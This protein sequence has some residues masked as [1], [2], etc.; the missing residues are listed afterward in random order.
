MADF[1]VN[2]TQLS[3]PSGAGTAP[4]GPAKGGLFDN[5]VGDLIGRTLSIF[6]KGLELDKKDKAKQT[7]DAVLN[8]YS[9]RLAGISS[10]LEQGS[11]KP[12]EAN[13]RQRAITNEFLAAHGSLAPKFSQVLDSFNGTTL[14]TAR[15]EE[16][17][18]RASFNKQLDAARNDGI[19]IPDSANP[20]IKNQLV[21]LHQE[22]KF[23]ER[24][25]QQMY[26]RAS[27]EREQ[28]RYT[29]EVAKEQARQM[30]IQQANALADNALATSD[31]QLRVL[32]EAVSNGSMKPEDAALQWNGYMSRID[33]ALQGTNPEIA[34]GYRS[35]F[36][37]MREQG[38]EFFKPGA[39]TKELE[40]A[41]AQRQLGSKLAV[42][43]D[44]DV[45]K[46]YTTLEL[47]KNI[48]PVVLA[49]TP[50]VRN[51]TAKL[52]NGN[53]TSSVPII[54]NKGDGGGG[55]TVSTQVFSVLKKVTDDYASGKSLNPQSKQEMATGINKALS[56]VGASVGSTGFKS[57]DLND[58]V[59]F[60]SSPSFGKFAKENM[61]DPQATSNARVAFRQVYE[62]DLLQ[63]VSSILNKTFDFTHLVPQTDP[64]KPV[65]MTR[66]ETF[67]IDA[68]NIAITYD[69][70]NVV[71]G[72]KKLPDNPQERRLLN[73]AINE[74]APLQTRMGQMVRIRAHLAGSTDYPA[75][76]EQTKNIM[77]GQFFPNAEA[78]KD[79][80]A[81]TPI[82]ES[83]ARE[84]DMKVYLPMSPAEARRD[85]NNERSPANL[86]EL[87]KEI[88]R[89]KNP[90]IKRVL[91]DYRKQLTGGR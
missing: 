44:P 47:F 28:G 8:N 27:Y 18:A 72:V 24:Q 50:T 63:S 37:P 16:R 65:E 25:T 76:W 40:D 35:I 87:D 60:F 68:N 85:A 26:Q 91:E 10:A 75:Y 11:I 88:A 6:E 4:V 57:T 30:G 62:K 69:R 22:Q 59:T 53:D 56:Q 32:R 81:G 80:G 84:A 15:D 46:A 29:S 17:E 74:L 13:V 43:S 58:A 45:M 31:A 7:E 5:G 21:Q 48:G 49:T 54:G 3:A 86:A 33:A 79:L 23:I 39:K 52:F 1:S 9:A 64:R 34:A 83:L 41:W 55:K 19:V 61:L 42:T 20:T 67:K 36:T 90:E 14:G 51:L 73:Q 66:K 89:T 2:A 78:P 38:L 12:S 77:F 71:F 82:S 70:G